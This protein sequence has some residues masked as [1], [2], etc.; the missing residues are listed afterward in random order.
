MTSKNTDFQIH[1]YEKTYTRFSFYKNILYKNIDDEIGQKAKN[2]LRICSSWNFVNKVK[3][4]VYKNIKAEIWFNIFGYISR[5]IR[6]ETYLTMWEESFCPGIQFW[7]IFEGGRGRT[8][9]KY[10]PEVKNIWGSARFSVFL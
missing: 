10:H 8:F 6:L 5:N 7:G 4:I 1:L 3:N 9:K 2:I